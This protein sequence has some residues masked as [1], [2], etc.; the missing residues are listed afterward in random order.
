ML[1][2]V[3]D[4][5]TSENANDA[6]N[7]IIGVSNTGSESCLQC[8]EGSE[9]YDRG[10][11][12]CNQDNINFRIKTTENLPFI[13]SWSK[14]NGMLYGDNQCEGEKIIPSIKAEIDKEYWTEIRYNDSK[15]TI[16]I[17]DD[18]N[19]DKTKSVVTNE[20]CSIPTELKFLRFSMNDGKPI[21]NGG[22]LTG[23]ID[24]IEIFESSYSK[25]KSDGSENNLEKIY[26]ED[27]SECKTKNCDGWIL[28]NPNAFFV[29][30]KEERFHFDSY[31]SG[32]N[33]YAHY[34]LPEP[35]SQEEWMI[36]LVLSFDHIEEF[37]HGKGILGISPFER[38]LIFIV[39]SVVIAGITSIFSIK[40]KCIG[41]SILIIIFAIILF[42]ASFTPLV[43]NQ[44]IF[45][46]ESLEKIVI[47]LGLIFFSLILISF[48]ICRIY[49][50]IK[51]NSYR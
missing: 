2:Y 16:S 1:I 22:R 37:P 50:R 40:Q 36:R 29:D 13:S 43:N 27:F 26:E 3:V 35:L 38:N 14:D 11:K 7:I 19:F 5:S 45:E 41:I 18:K 51:N 44:L 21:S 20:V 8:Q 42:Y 12:I 39:T 23:N 34:E 48:G 33:D 6:S 4:K 25:N 31:I 15:Y 46:N 30:V 49:L 17:Y 9:F 28:Q 24:N 10:C 47:I 32:T